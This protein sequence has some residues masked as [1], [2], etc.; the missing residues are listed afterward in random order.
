MPRVLNKHLTPRLANELIESGLGVYVGRPSKWGNQYKIEAGQTRTEAIEK[1]ER[2]LL[3]DPA[4]VDEARRELR[5]KDLI[6]WCRPLRCHA[7][8]LLKVAN[9]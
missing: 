6:C 1:Y 3:N 8:V 5:G 7:D 4:R 2:D 9:G